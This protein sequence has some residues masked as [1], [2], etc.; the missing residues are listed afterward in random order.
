MMRSAINLSS[1][2]SFIFSRILSCFT[3]VFLIV[4]ISVYVSF[5]GIPRLF[6]HTNGPIL[7]RPWAEFSHVHVLHEESLSVT[8][9]HP[10]LEKTKMKFILCVVDDMDKHFEIIIIHEGYFTKLCDN[11]TY[12]RGFFLYP[13]TYSY[14]KLC[15]FFRYDFNYIRLIK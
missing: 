5:F 9:I 13:S 3:S 6:T 2:K 4:A 8:H 14:I 10:G 1:R 15:G 7:I 11:L 12:I